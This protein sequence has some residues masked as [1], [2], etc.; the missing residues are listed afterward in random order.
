MLKMAKV[1]AIVVVAS[2]F[3]AGNA[4]AA[5][6]KAGSSCSK[7]NQALKVGSKVALRCQKVGSKL[8]W[9][10]VGSPTSNN[11][12]ATSSASPSA[13]ASA[14]PTGTQPANTLAIYNGG[15]GNPGLSGDQPSFDLPGTPPTGYSNFNVRFWTYDPENPKNASNSDGIF[16]QPTGGTFAYSPLTSSGYYLANWTPGVYALDVT[17]PNN[18]SVKYLRHRYCVTVSASGGV[19]VDGLQPNSLGFFTL[20]VDLAPTPIK[21][22]PF[23]P[24]TP[25]QLQYQVASD[26]QL[27]DG[28]PRK[29][30]R[31]PNSGTVH[32][33]IV[34]VDFSDAPGSGDPAQV[35]YDMATGTKNFY[36]KISGGRVKFDFQI[37]PTWQ[38]QSFLS[39]AYNLGTYNGGDGFGYYKAMVAAEDKYIDY[40]KFDVV[41]FLSPPTIAPTQIAYGP[42]M[43]TPVMT[44]DGVL[45]SGAISGADA[46]DVKSIVGDGWKWMSHETGHLMGLQDL[47]TYGTTTFGDWDIMKMNWTDNFIEM[48]AWNRYVEGWLTDSQIACYT[49]STLPQKGVTLTLDPLERE[50]NNLKAFALPLSST[51]ILV[52]ESRRSEGLD[53]SSA[54]QP[55]GTIV[56][57][58]D[59]TL[60]SLKG[61]WQQIVPTRTRDLTN[62]SDSALQAGESVTVGG[63]T[64]TVIKQDSTGDTIK[65]VKN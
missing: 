4:S 47:Y 22:T 65:V 28:F 44:A 1:A 64:L 38:R 36:D 37:L 18:N 39:T 25:C 30:T 12:S 34:P 56:Y 54:N 32:A 21:V 5:T 59:M 3:L 46:W 57:T 15:P 24:T 14:S 58:V 20:T 53:S 9:V 26:T 49:A 43:V 33:L 10:A 48:D 52:A 19:S 23:T 42:A 62:Y 27:T 17:E 55:A 8:K 31:L 51:Q 40:S 41:Y 7:V 2:M 63:Y 13:T 11:A 29:S 35:Y 45:R 61:A 60:G 50:N 6:P 16:V